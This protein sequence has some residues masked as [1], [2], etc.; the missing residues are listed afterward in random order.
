MS[1]IITKS[2]GNVLKIRRSSRHLHNTEINRGEKDRGFEITETITKN[3]HIG[4]ASKSTE[5]L[6]KHV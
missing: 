3:N 2:C 5:L 6:T 1:K 4:W